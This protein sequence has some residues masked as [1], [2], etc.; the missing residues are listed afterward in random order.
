M[1]AQPRS[2][3]IEIFD[4]VEVQQDLITLDLD[5]KDEIRPFGQ[6]PPRPPVTLKGHDIAVEVRAQNH[7]VPS[8]ATMCRDTERLAGSQ[9]GINQ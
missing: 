9:K 1:T 4:P 8:S 5:L 6:D 2:Q 7:R 3:G